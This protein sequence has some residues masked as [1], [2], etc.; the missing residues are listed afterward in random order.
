VIC[1]HVW[2]AFASHGNSVLSAC[3][4]E[5]ITSHEDAPMNI[6]SF[7]FRTKIMLVAL[8]PVMIIF[9]VILIKKGTTTKLVVTE[10][11]SQ[12]RNNLQTIAK[13]IYSFCEIQSGSLRGD[14]PNGANTQAL[15]KAIMS[16]KIGKTGYAYVLGGKGSSKGRYIISK[17]GARDG[18]YVWNTKDA[19]GN[20]PI[21]SICESGIKL[22]PGEI[23]YVRYL[24][25]NQGESKA[26]WKL[27]AVTYF[28]P[29]DWVIGADAYED[30]LHQANQRVAL[31]MN[32]LAWSLVFW[33]FGALAI[34]VVVGLFIAMRIS[35]SMKCLTNV[36]DQLALGNVDVHLDVNGQDE[37]A[38]LSR[39]MHTMV[40]NIKNQASIAFE[41][42]HGNLDVEAKKRSDKDTLANSMN[43]M[44]STLRNLIQEIS[45]LT[46]AAIQG[47]PATRSEAK[48]FDGAYRNIILGINQTMDV[49]VKPIHEASNVLHTLA[50]RDLTA[51]MTGEYQGDLA[52]LKQSINQATQNLDN[53]L[54]QTSTSAEEVASAA[55]QISIGSQSLS[56]GA[57]EQASALEQVSGRMQE[58]AIITRHNAEYS[59]QARE[60]TESARKDTTDGF[61]NMKRLSIAI[62]KIKQSSYKTAEIIKTIDEIAFQTNL[63]ALNAAVEAARAGDAGKGF[64][65][66]AEEVRNLAMRSAVAAKDTAA[67]I[68]ESVRNANEGVHINEEMLKNLETINTH[69][70]KVYEVMADIASASEQQTEGISEIAAALQQM[71]GITQQTAANSEEAAGASEE[72]STQANEMRTMV[73]SFQLTQ[74]GQSAVQE[75]KYDAYSYPENREKAK[76]IKHHQVSPLNKISNPGSGSS[77]EAFAS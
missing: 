58:F 52:K 43:L 32:D 30:E 28:A 23:T 7:N 25:K 72:L 16:T 49:I 55:S 11:D 63:L 57:S 69:V 26:R 29:W 37:I 27:V 24:W 61:D 66:V 65:V 4:K 48:G 73:E 50:K 77:S 62:E 60:I 20:Y 59:R 70:G 40:E 75:Q 71:N 33:G 21:Q 9:G 39:S 68:E 53:A 51:R 2:R 44:L 3:A 15:K 35:G 67:M 1:E 74:T 38:T 5:R 14:S 18:E 31:A 13:N 17:D 12:A 22:N 45:K 34:A 41:I 8:L 46:G 64:A 10:L 47:R 42:A 56:Q 6:G 19:E 76:F 36:A 54:L